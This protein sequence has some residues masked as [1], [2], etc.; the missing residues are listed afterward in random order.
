MFAQVAARKY[1]EQHTY[2][3]GTNLGLLLPFCAL[4]TLPPSCPCVT[5]LYS[6]AHG[7]RV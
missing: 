2:D 1:R 4:F 3:V 6:A 5:V 7:T